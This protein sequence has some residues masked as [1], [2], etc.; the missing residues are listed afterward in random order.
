MLL[1]AFG[2]LS[3]AYA[4]SPRVAVL[5]LENKTGDPRF[6][7]IGAIA[8]GLLQYDLSSSG[9]LELV[10]RSVLDAALRERELSLSAIAAE[11]SRMPKGLEG[12]DFLLA[13]EYVLIGKDVLLT[14]KLVDVA[15]TR[16][17]AFSEGG[18]TENLVHVLA[19]R[20]VERL[21]GKRPSLVQQGRGRSLL[22]LRDETPG[23][24]ALHSPLIDAEILLD[25]SFIG[26]TT[27][28]RRKPFLID[29]LE[30]GEHV[31]STNLGRDF[32]V[33]QLPEIRFGPWTEKVSVPSGKRVVVTDTS[34]H[35]N[36]ILY[37]LMRLVSDSRQVVF[38]NGRFS[39]RKAFTF[40][41]RSRAVHSGEIV[42]EAAQGKDGNPDA[43]TAAFILDGIRKD[44][45]FT[46][47]GERTAEIRETMG[48]VSFGLDVENRSG[49]IVFEI[50]AE[51]TD[52]RQGMHREGE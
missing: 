48:L 26:Y 34:A 8:G 28:D 29:N 30:P 17:A 12:A 41:D 16:A 38:Q 25:G 13:G 47:E 44:V 7:Y 19:E 10:D 24:I 4:A 40:T 1:F 3:F 50:E 45:S 21:T 39:T 33:V 20:V 14:L 23:S 31:V 11:P 18:G 37:G 9:S 32:G 52:V 51:R 36:H 6:D 46:L 43:G 49:R 22:S 15:T 42:V 5:P 27:G 35:F 2:P